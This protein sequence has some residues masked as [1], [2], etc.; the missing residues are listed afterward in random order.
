MKYGRISDPGKKREYRNPSC[1]VVLDMIF[2]DSVMAI[3]S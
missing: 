1:F 3:L 2:A